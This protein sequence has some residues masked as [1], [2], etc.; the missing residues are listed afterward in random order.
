V[1]QDAFHDQCGG[2]HED[3]GAGPSTASDRQE[4]SRCHIL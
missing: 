1:R 3:Y 4:C 2:C